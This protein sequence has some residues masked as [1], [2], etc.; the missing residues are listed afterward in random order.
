MSTAA[1]VVIEANGQVLVVERDVGSQMF[2][3]PGGKREP[4]ETFEDAAV[5]EL[6]EETGVSVS[7]SDLQKV[8]ESDDGDYTVVAFTAKKYRGIPTSHEN[9][10][11]RWITWDE[12]CA[13]DQPFS[14]YNSALRDVTLIKQIDLAENVDVESVKTA[15]G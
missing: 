5:R 4:G 13:P 12:L 11:V 2:G 6:L 3:L 7:A 8:Y 1:V 15:A 14:A 10:D 9:R